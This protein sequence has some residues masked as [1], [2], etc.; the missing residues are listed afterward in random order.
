M[1]NIY[2]KISK[3]IWYD[4]CQLSYY[5]YLGKSVMRYKDEGKM[6]E[7]ITISYLVLA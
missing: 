5:K 2:I 3:Y 7:V 6:H 1:G 4:I